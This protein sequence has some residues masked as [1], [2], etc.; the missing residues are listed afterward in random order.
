MKSQLV[1]R[2]VKKKAIMNNLINKLENEDDLK[3]I[4]ESKIK[5]KY[6]NNREEG[7]RN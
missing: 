7:Q 4:I 5:S 6:Q 1:A 3:H 2:P